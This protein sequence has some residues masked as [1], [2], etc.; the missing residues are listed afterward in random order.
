MCV[1][2]NRELSAVNVTVS[3]CYSGI[4]FLCTDII[5]WKT[6][7]HLVAI[8]RSTDITQQSDVYTK[9]LVQCID[10]LCC[11]SWPCF[12]AGHFNTPTIDKL[13]NVYKCC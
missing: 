3:N 2:V 9:Q 13:D 4:E 12:I 10:N 7:C 1:L 6:I 11:V 5:R 8:Y